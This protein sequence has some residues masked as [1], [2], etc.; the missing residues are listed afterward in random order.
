MGIMIEAVKKAA[1][2]KKEGKDMKN[3]EDNCL[4][5]YLAG[6]LWDQFAKEKHDFFSLKYRLIPC[7][8]E[9]DE[10]EYLYYIDV[11][12][13]GQEMGFAIPE[14]FKYNDLKEV[15]SSIHSWI[16]TTYEEFIPELPDN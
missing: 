2:K 3:L 11:F 4:A 15:A 9:R 5:E 16:D 1:L 10:N 14:D 6:I 13:L 8:F 12:F 7:F